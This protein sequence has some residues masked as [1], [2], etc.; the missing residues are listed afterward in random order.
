MKSFASIRLHIKNSIYVQLEP[1]KGLQLKIL[2]FIIKMY[3]T[4]FQPT[5]DFLVPKTLAQLIYEFL[6]NLIYEHDVTISL[7]RM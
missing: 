3:I 5:C 1:R 7:L 4:T 2:Y 6:W